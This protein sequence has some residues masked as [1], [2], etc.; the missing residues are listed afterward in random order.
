MDKPKQRQFT[1]P[2]GVLT[3]VSGRQC[4]AISGS[5]LPER[6]GFG[7]A[8]AQSAARQTRLCPSQPYYGL[9]PAMFSGT[10][11]ITW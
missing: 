2:S 6:T 11:M 8:V 10:T 7:P 5:P 4:S 9:H 3:S 1:I